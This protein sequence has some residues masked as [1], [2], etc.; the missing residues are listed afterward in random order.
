MTK[1][2]KTTFSLAW[3]LVVLG[4][5][6]V[7]GQIDRARIV[8]TVTDRDVETTVFDDITNQQK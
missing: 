2:R 5:I 4:S 3:V 7:Q 6:A 8:G 1:Q